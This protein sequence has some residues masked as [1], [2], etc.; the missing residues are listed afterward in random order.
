MSVFEI[1]SFNLYVFLC[2][3]G[4]YLSNKSI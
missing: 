2:V 3:R 4:S 1:E